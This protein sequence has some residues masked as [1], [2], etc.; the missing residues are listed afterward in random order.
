MSI[1]FS[2]HCPNS[3]NVSG[4]WSNIV[5]CVAK[6]KKI[7][8]WKQVKHVLTYL[9]CGTILCANSHA[10]SAQQGNISTSYLYKDKR[11]C[12]EK[13][14]IKTGNS[15]DAINMICDSISYPEA[16]TVKDPVSA[17]IAPK[18]E[19]T[20]ED[21]IMKKANEYY[22]EHIQEYK[23]IYER[24]LAEEKKEE[25]KQ[26]KVR[27][28]IAYFEKDCLE[29]NYRDAD[30]WIGAGARQGIRR[31]VNSALQL[32]NDHC[33]SMGNSNWSIL[34]EKDGDRHW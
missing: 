21:R 2:V 3:I 11:E 4:A 12:L 9:I 32:I 6:K 30:T 10:A 8:L 19:E 31:D 16:R 18:H 17:K 28:A 7:S 24:K 20:E 33:K 1:N 29:K 15:D 26:I 34:Y 22:K 13:N 25:E 23:N 27:Q 14:K 5:N